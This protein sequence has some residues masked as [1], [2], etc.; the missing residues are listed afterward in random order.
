MTQLLGLA[1]S[2]LPNHSPSFTL[3]REKFIDSELAWGVGGGGGG[4]GRD[5]RFIEFIYGTQKYLLVSNQSRARYW[6]KKIKS[7]S[8]A[9]QY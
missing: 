4:G 5:S 6:K 1:S 2:S 8:Q 3:S 9:D 7:A